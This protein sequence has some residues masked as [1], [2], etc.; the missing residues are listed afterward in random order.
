MNKKR[1]P[2]LPTTSIVSEGVRMNLSEWFEKI[3]GDAY[4][5]IIKKETS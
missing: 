1:I 2:K 3:R 5:K 4:N